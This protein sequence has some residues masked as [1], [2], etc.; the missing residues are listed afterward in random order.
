[1]PEMSADVEH[2]NVTGTAVETPTAPLPPAR[3]LSVAPAAASPSNGNPAGS[4]PAS[5]TEAQQTDMPRWRVTAAGYL[6][7]TFGFATAL[8]IPHLPLRAGLVEDA[9][10]IVSITA[11]LAGAATVVASFVLNLLRQL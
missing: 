7:L 8:A 4:F 9:L 6:I 5:V 11:M 10:V 2:P 3:P 1:M